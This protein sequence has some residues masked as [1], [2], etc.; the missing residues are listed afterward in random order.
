MDERSYIDPEGRHPAEGLLI[1]ERHALELQHLWPG[2][3][4]SRT[5]DAIQ[6]DY[7]G[8]EGITVLVTAEALELRLPTV[9]WTMGSYGPAATSRLWK[10][11]PWE[12]HI[13]PERLLELL[14]AALAERQAEFSTCRFCEQWLPPEHMHEHDIC[15]SCAEKHLGVVH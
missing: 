8:E 9:E 15:Q 11:V 4:L 13:K 2:A 1:V 12:Q 14:E 3:V 5:R 10:R 6:L 7:G